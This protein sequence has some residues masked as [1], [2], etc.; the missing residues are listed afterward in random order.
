MVWEDILGAKLGV[1]LLENFN[2]KLNDFWIA[3][4]RGLV[5]Q[6]RTTPPSDPPVLG[7]RGGSLPYCRRKLFPFRFSHCRIKARLYKSLS[8]F[9]CDFA[10]LFVDLFEVIFVRFP[11]Q[12]AMRKMHTLLHFFLNAF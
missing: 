8:F 5:R 11:V 9:R 4:G 7:P 2:N 1:K 3:L 12:V 10:L 6:Q